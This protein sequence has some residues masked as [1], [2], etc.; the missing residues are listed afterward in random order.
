MASSELAKERGTYS[1]YKGSKWDRNLFPL[2]TIALLEQERGVKVDVSR[3]SRLDW[4]PVRAFVK[5]HGMRNSNVLSIAPTATISNIAGSYPCIEPA[6]RN[7]YVK[8]NIA[9]E[10]TIVN[11]FLMRD[12]K[13]ARFMGSTNA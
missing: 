12:L 7:L 3:T 1:S 5:Q 10:F 2:D 4:A 8:S 9:G 13:E 11:R 6:Y